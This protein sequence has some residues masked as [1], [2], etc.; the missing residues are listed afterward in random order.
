MTELLLIRHAVNDWVNTGRLAGW[1]PNVHLNTHGKAQA[2][3]LG[4]RLANASLAAIYT[5][6]LERTQ[7]TAAAIAI[8][9]PQ[10]KVQVIDGVGE[11]R[12]GEWQG[13]KLDKLR[14][15]CW[16]HGSDLHI[17][18]LKSSGIKSFEDIKG[19]RFAV[20]APGSG[21]QV[22][23]FRLMTEVYENSAKDY[24][25]EFLSFAEAVNA[26][27][28]NRI[29]A[30]VVMAGAPVASVMDLAIV[31]DIRLIPVTRE[32][33]NKLLEIYPIYDEYII[34]TGMYKG[35]DEDILTFT[36]PANIVTSSDLPADLVYSVLKAL[37]NKIPWLTENVHKGFKR[38]K[39]DPSVQRIA[40]LHD[41]AI[42]FYK[43]MGKM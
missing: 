12:F 27:K 30:G 31:K 26:L 1:T 24:K 32:K 7:E 37:Y 15:M 25:V 8:H 21:T 19:K 5:S 36:S 2:A 23:V 14:T 3:A 13:Q 34:K 29:D 33:I 40:P 17:I 39:F 38:W 43:E 4:E 18:T 41:G 11:V 35:I 16:G 10:L 6:P 22:N 28:D 42:K 9:Y 20:G